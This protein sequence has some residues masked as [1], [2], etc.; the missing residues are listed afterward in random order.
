MVISQLPSLNYRRDFII[1]ARLNFRTKFMWKCSDAHRLQSPINGQQ[2]NLYNRT[3]SSQQWK[4]L[5]SSLASCLRPNL[6]YAGTLFG[7]PLTAQV[8]CFQRKSDQN[9]KKFCHRVKPASVEEERLL[10]YDIIAILDARCN[11]CP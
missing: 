1:G 5:L 3:N 6:F 10:I 2:L 9:F 4:K 11:Y 7:W 8:S